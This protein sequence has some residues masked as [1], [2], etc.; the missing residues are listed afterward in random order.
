MEKV[1]RLWRKQIKKNIGTVQC[2]RTHLQTALPVTIGFWL[3]NLHNR[4]VKR[5]RISKKDALDIEGIFSGAVGTFASQSILLKSLKGEKTL[6]RMLGLK[7][8]EVSTQIAPPETKAQVY[9]DMLLL[10]GTM[11]NLGE[12]VR[13]LQS[14][15]FG[16]LISPSSSSSA[17]PHKKANPI[18]A[19]NDAGMHIDV[20]AEFFK[21]AATL[22]S[23]L[24]RDLRWSCVMRSFSAVAVYTYQQ[25]L[26]TERILKN[27]KV[28]KKSCEGN[29][30]KA[31]KLV[32]AEPLHLYLQNN[33]YP[34]THHLLNKEI[35]PRAAKSGN[36]LNTELLRYIEETGDKKLKKLYSKMPKDI[37]LVLME[38]KKYIGQAKKIAEREAKNKL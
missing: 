22:V 38:P 21:I 14:S 26:T 3:T 18:A 15:Q 35:V 2:G 11:A 31:G 12:D 36:N 24:Q 16:E 30:N 5:G 6:M 17:M 34:A 7:C 4:F 37:L 25:L 19:E 33:G 32:V 20:Q 1:D 28:D 8:A 29:F 10:S 9:F 23:D 27:L 13:I